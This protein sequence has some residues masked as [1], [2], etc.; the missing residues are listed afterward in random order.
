LS[1]YGS[2]LFIFVFTYYTVTSFA[3]YWTWY[4]VLLSKFRNVT[5][6]YSWFIIPYAFCSFLKVLTRIYTSV[7]E[8]TTFS[9]FLTLRKVSILINC[10][11]ERFYFWSFEINLWFINEILILMKNLSELRSILKLFIWH[12]KNFCIL[13]W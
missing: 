7:A 11:F 2:E 3:I 8:N 10:C 13:R 12:L 5:I 4:M 9:W 1:T 6:V